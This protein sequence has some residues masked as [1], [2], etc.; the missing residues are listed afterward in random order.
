M[1]FPLYFEMNIFIAN[2]I[3]KNQYILIFNFYEIL[4]LFMLCILK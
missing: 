1:Y 3:N 2:N 4:I